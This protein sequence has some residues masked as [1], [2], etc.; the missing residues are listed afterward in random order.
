M[1][2]CGW[3]LMTNRVSVVAER[4]TL[5]IPA[6]LRMHCDGADTLAVN[7]GTVRAAL[8]AAGKDHAALVQHI[9]TRAGELRPFVRV[10]VR[11]NDVRGLGGLDTAL[12]DG[13]TVAI[14]PSV[15]GG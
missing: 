14:V 15:A 1:R 2:A 13:D 7:A 9:L 12:N 5:L 11:N 6:A 8:A 10:F 3:V 4:V